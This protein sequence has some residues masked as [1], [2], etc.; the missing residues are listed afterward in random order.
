[1][2]QLINKHFK[3]FV[4][5]FILGMFFSCGSGGNNE[6]PLPNPENELHTIKYEASISSDEYKMSILYVAYGG[7]KDVENIEI[8][9]KTKWS[10]EMKD[11]SDYRYV[12]CSCKA[13][14]KDPNNK[15][16]AD[17]TVSLYVDGKLIE[18][19][20]GEFVAIVGSITGVE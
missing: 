6:E 8:D 2:E 1:M 20:T 18:K 15:K 19:D 13:L 17:V 14:P 7:K 16:D 11:I 9:D 10:F 3:V 4:V 12:Y 5:I